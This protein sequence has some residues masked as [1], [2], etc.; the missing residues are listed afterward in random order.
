MSYYNKRRYGGGG[1]GG[2]YNRSYGGNGGGYSGGYSEPTVDF[3]E[4]TIV[5]VVDDT[6]L[7]SLNETI[8][9]ND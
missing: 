2:G 7:L 9:L 6:S 5:N 4:S 3:S 1:Y 8:V